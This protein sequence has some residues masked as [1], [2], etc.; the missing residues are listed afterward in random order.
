MVGARSALFLPFENLG[1]IVV[2]E[3]HD[4]SYKQEDGAIYNARDMAVVRAHLAGFPVVLSSAT[5]SIESRVN[6]ERGRYQRLH[7]PDRYGGAPA[8]RSSRSTCA[9][10]PPERGRWLSPPLVAASRETLARGE[11]ALLF[12]NRRGYAPLTLCRA[13]G[14]RFQ[15]PNC[16]TLAGRAPL[17]RRLVCHHCG[18]LEPRPEVCPH[19]GDRTAWR[20]RPGLERLAE[21]VAALFPEARTIALSSD[22]VGGVSACGCELQA[23]AEGEFDIVIGTQLVAKGHH[24]PVARPWS[25]WSTPT[26]AWPTAISAPPSAP[27]SCCL[28]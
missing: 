16:S 2:D 15:C 6:A 12:L 21:E 14:H 7:L 18:H 25:A 26:S 28:R 9:R 8:R 5:P 3:E 24:F 20:R 27:S 10:R 19:C 1:L 17:P 23:I 22:L 4:L 11:Q 13:C